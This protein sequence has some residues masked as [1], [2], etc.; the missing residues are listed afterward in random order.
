M[1][2]KMRLIFS[3]TGTSLVHMKSAGV[4]VI[5]EMQMKRMG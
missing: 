1:K 5:C 2:L 3:P 4:Y